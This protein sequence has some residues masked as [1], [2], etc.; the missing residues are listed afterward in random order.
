MRKF[1]SVIFGLVLLAAAGA[2]LWL[3]LG[4]T[5]TKSV[6]TGGVLT[7]QQEIAAQ[8]IP[9]DSG[10]APDLG[11][12]TDEGFSS[13]NAMGAA[14]QMEA[15][16]MNDAAALD[17]GEQA[18]APETAVSG[19]VTTDVLLDD[20]SNV[21]VAP[22]SIT[23]AQSLAAPDG[24][25]GAGATSLT[26]EQ[27]VVELE[28]PAS[29]PVGKSGSVRVTLKALE[30]GSLQPIAEIADN[31]VLATPILIADR[32]DTHNAV[33]TASLSAPDF[34]VEPLSNAD[35]AMERG[36]E[37][38]WRWTVEASETGT[39]VIVIN[40][41][42]TWVPFAEGASPISAAI[43]GQALQIESDYVLGLLT[44]KQASYGGTAL[45]VLGLLAEI[46]LLGKL[47]EAIWHALFGPRRKQ[48]RRRQR[49]R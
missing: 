35:Q 1:L 27:R 49:R 28:W 19:S 23:P 10:I 9:L 14:P 48:D 41:T 29:L 8:N 13:T 25:G 47:L 43:W 44:I 24:Q 2:L 40:L 11:V 45:A 39:S 17:A 16:A 36:G 26:Y 3:A 42:L 15:A 18:A 37:V 12:I 7:T 4:P 30:D 33:V 6:T 38:A 46:P 31:E 21:E 32:Y 34:T 5:S 20:A 22:L